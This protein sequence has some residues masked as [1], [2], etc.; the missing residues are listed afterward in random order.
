IG[1]ASPMLQEIFAGKLIGLPDVS[2]TQ[3]DAG[4]KTA[5]ASIAAGFAGL[6]SLFNI[7]GRFFWASLSDRIG[8][9]ATYFTFFALG[10]VLY[11]LAPT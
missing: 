6:I 4:Q 7:G 5:I 11:A 1:M 10:I 3:L 9:K 8:R 2:F